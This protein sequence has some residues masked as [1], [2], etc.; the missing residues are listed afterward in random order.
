MTPEYYISPEVFIRD[1][2]YHWVFLD[3]A[4]DRYLC[5]RRSDFDEVAPWIALDGPGTGRFPHDRV[6]PICGQ[7]PESVEKALSSLVTE[8]LITRTRPTAANSAW[9]RW[10]PPHNSLLDTS[11]RS[12]EATG[13]HLALRFAICAAKADFQLRYFTIS[14]IVQRIRIRKTRFAAIDCDLDRVAA[15]I[16]A[17]KGLRWF[18]PRDYLCLFDCLALLELLA[19]YGIYPTW[20]FAIATDPFQA[21]CWL[22]HENT[23]LN[24]SLHRVVNYVPIMTV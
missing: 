17:F 3:L 2:F 20:V 16:A 9:C 6:P 13:V 19:G 1:C 15:L 14:R 21:H 11:E 7:P 23:V 24:D 8:G 18:Y 4:R 10:A 22:Q 5:V 12:L